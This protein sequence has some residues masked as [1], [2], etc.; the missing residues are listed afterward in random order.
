MPNIVHVLKEEIRR[1]A[2]KEA[3]A[4][5]SKLKKDMVK[6]KKSNVAMRRILKQLDRDSGLLLNAEK[7]RCQ[8][9]QNAPVI[10]P[11][12]SRARVTAKGIRA[13]RK[14][15]GVSQ[16]GFAKL[17]GVSSQ[18]VLIWEHKDGALRVKENTRAA[19]L[20]LR[21]IG[22]REA[23]RRLEMVAAKKVVGRKKVK[24]G[25]RKMAKGKKVVKKG[26][27]K[28][29]KRARKSGRR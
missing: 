4:L 16:A 1:L 7:R 5:T 10:A 19:I 9:Q 28:R 14:K 3:K 17:V 25:R 26:K 12:K 27:A 21:G 11:E 22:A 23:K 8:S 6:L 24:W 15:L 20:A 29:A 13:M 2:K 18:M